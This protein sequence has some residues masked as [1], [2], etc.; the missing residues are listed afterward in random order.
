[1]TPEVLTHLSNKDKIL[2]RLIAQVG[3]CTFKQ[4]RRTPF[5]ALVRAV[6]YQQLHGT[7]A[8][9]IFRRLKGLFPGRPFPS[10]QAILATSDERLRSA[11]LS[12]AKTAAIKDIAAKT[13]EGIIPRSREIAKLTEI[14]ILERLTTVRGVGPWTVDMLLIF[15]LGRPDVLPVTD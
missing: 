5:H 12:R 7:A 13:I 4:K 14:E 1:M 6:T 10:P 8:E 9:T 2:G 3:P 15:T 11:G